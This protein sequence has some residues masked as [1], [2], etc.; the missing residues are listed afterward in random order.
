MSVDHHDGDIEG[1][2]GHGHDVDHDHGDE[3]MWRRRR[4]NCVIMI[5]GGARP[6]R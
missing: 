6:S 3:H 2:D 1:D 4:C 5:Y